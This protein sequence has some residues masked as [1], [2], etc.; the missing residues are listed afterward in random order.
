MRTT[1]RCAARTR[2]LVVVLTQ[3]EGHQYGPGMRHW[4]MKTEPDEF[5]YDDLVREGR[6]TWDGVRN[7]QARNLMREMRRGDLVVIYHSNTSPPGAAGI[8]RVVGESEPDPT[9]FD[10]T[11][12]QF[13]PRATPEAPRWDQVPL[14]PERH[15][16][17]VPLATLRTLP[18]L[19]DSQLL[20]RGNRLS[21]LALSA[22]EFDA[23]EASSRGSVD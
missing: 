3:D 5:S 1:G 2:N 6:T 4:L 15:L 10:P 21:V 23:I 14:A 7:Y 22:V 19:G 18:E 9:Q 20:S 8:A 12:D 16:R 17:F 13:D 11:S